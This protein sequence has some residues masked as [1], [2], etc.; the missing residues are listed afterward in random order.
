MG[1]AGGEKLDY[2]KNLHSNSS[3]PSS[4]DKRVFTGNSHRAFP[5]DTAVNPL[6][7]GKRKKI[8]FSLVAGTGKYA[9]KALHS[10]PQVLSG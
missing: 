7:K 1:F 2:S 3:L 4:Q 9:G 5:Y 8:K 10:D 6:G